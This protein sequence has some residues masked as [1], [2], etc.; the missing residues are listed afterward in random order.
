MEDVLIYTY[1]KPTFKILPRSINQKDWIIRSIE[2][3]RKAGYSIIELYTDDENFAQ[4]LNVN[5]T[6]FINDDYSIWDSFKLWVLENRKDTNYILTD[7]DVIFNKKIEFDN[8]VDISFDAIEDHNWDWAYKPLMDYLK[9]NKIFDSIPFWNYEKLDV[10]NVGILKINNDELR[11]DYINYW[12]ELYK[13]AEPYFKNIDIKSL[14]PIL[15]QYL[16]SIL[17]YNKN[18]KSEHFT[19][20]HG[21]PLNNKYYQHYPGRLKLKK[22]Q[23]I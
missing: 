14:T 16:L 18:Y 10:L 5:K 8:L 6:H 13:L 7:N 20:N 1:K 15:T 21:W 22:T 12:K 3:A 23:L 19:L 2:S 11:V 4:D 9:T 17:V